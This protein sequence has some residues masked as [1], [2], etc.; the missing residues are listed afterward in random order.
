ME[1]IALLRRAK[2]NSQEI[3]K[4]I[5]ID[6]WENSLQNHFLTIFSFP[7]YLFN[8][9]NFFLPISL[10]LHF[11]WRNRAIFCNCKLL[12]PLRR[13]IRLNQLQNLIDPTPRPYRSATPLSYKS[14]EGIISQK[15][16]VKD[17][18]IFDS[19]NNLW[20]NSLNGVKR[21]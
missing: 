2:C 10:E 15:I 18:L 3:G 21:G 6:K 11:T 20:T 19:Q 9:C 8:R 5:I 7:T 16:L 13:P 4:K 17:L 14:W 1:K 12:F